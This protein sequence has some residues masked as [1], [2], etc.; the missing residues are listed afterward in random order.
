MC[1]V[2]RSSGQKIFML[3]SQWQFRPPIALSC[4]R[5]LAGE[6]HLNG[7]DVAATPATDHSRRLRRNVKPKIA[8]THNRVNRP[9]HWGYSSLGDYNSLAATS[10]RPTGDLKKSPKS[11]RK[12]SNMLDFTA[13]PLRPAKSP[14][15]VMATSLRPTETQVTAR[16]PTSLQ[17]SEIGA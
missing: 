14:G 7:R 13:T 4:K 17:A 9:Q 8:S 15:D 10:P 11:L 3:V 6:N 2:P 12:K 16:S 1:G 5:R